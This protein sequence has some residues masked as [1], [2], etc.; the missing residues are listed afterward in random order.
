MTNDNGYYPTRRLVNTAINA[1]G[2]IDLD[3]LRDWDLIS[4]F[5]S[6]TRLYSTMPKLK[7]QTQAKRL[8]AAIEDKYESFDNAAMAKLLKLQL[9]F[10]EA[11]ADVTIINLLENLWSGLFDA[12]D[13]P[14]LFLDMMSLFSQYHHAGI[15]E[16]NEGHHT[17]IQEAFLKTF[18]KPLT[19]KSLKNALSNLFRLGI[20]ELNPEVAQLLQNSLQNLGGKIG[21]F[22]PAIYAYSTY[23]GLDTEKILLDFSEIEKTHIEVRMSMLEEIDNLPLDTKA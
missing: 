2:E 22:N 6:L 17:Q 12:K 7:V 10:P 9:E 23:Y 18:T 11:L 21:R 4:N 20:Q 19:A 3:N 15:R 14:N 5:E 13:N 1:V 16:I 8:A